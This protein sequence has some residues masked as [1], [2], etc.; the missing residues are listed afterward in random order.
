MRGVS[1]PATLGPEGSMKCSIPARLTFALLAVVE[2]LADFCGETIP[3][4]TSLGGRKRQLV[5]PALRSG[6]LI[7]PLGIA[8]EEEIHVPGR[9]G[10]GQPK[11]TRVRLHQVA[12]GIPI[13]ADAL[14]GK[15]CRRP[16][17]GQAHV[18][19]KNWDP[20][21]VDPQIGRVQLVEYTTF[22]FGGPPKAGW[23]RRRQ[24]QEQTHL[25]GVFVESRVQ[26]TD[27]GRVGLPPSGEKLS[28]DE[29]AQQ[30]HDETGDESAACHLG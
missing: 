7:L 16:R 9:P 18:R 13:V 2:Q 30:D 10:V 22:D 23:S 3:I 25:A 17:Y 5:H 6:R 24:K 15:P 27:V 1:L 29:E 4:Q 8:I 21:C 12:F 19:A 20:N 14:I 28:N 11:N 26:R